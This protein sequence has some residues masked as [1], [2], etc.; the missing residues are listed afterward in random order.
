VTDVMNTVGAVGFAVIFHLG[1]KK[2]RNFSATGSG[3]PVTSLQ[4]L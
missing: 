2:E 1:S 4:I 3:F